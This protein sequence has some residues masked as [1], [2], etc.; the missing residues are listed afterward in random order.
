MAGKD[1]AKAAAAN[2]AQLAA[3]A[4]QVI[5][6]NR[7]LVLATGARRTRRCVSGVHQRHRRDG[8]RA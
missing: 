4:A 8:G 3:M 2:D 1:P 5:D 6:A 7:Y